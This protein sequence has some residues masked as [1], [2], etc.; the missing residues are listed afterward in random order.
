MGSC[1]QDFLSGTSILVPGKRFTENRTLQQSDETADN[2]L[3]SSA[4]V[5]MPSLIQPM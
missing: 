3:F 1:K 4:D 2:L 5:Q